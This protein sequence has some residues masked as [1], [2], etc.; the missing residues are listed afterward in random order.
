[1]SIELDAEGKVQLRS[2]LGTRLRA[3]R[4]AAKLTEMDAARAVGQ[5]EQTQVSLWETGQRMPTLQ[6]IIKLADLYAVPL[7]WLLGR[8]DDPIADPLETNQGVVVGII[9]SAMRGSFNKLCTAIAEEAAVTMEGYSIDRRELREMCQLSSDAQKALTRIIELNP[10]F[11]E[12]WRGSATLKR[13][14]TQMADKGREF[15][16]RIENERLRIEVIDREVS[17]SSMHN[18][19]AQFAMTFSE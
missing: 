6:S 8:T 11:E 3:A 7:D 5:K 2:L 1:M 12:S 15:G 13:A 10:E 17:W 14:L 9:S 19:V 18:E 4:K 16:R